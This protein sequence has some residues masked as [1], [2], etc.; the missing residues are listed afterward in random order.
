MPTHRLTYYTDHRKYGNSLSLSLQRFCLKIVSS[1]RCVRMLHNEQRL[2][3][4]LILDKLLIILEIFS[5]VNF[6]CCSGTEFKVRDIG[7]I[8]ERK[9]SNVLNMQKKKIEIHP[10]KT[11]VIDLWLLAS[12]TLSVLL[13]L[14]SSTSSLLRNEVVLLLFVA[15][16]WKCWIKNFSIRFR[17]VNNNNSTSTRS[18]K[19]FV[20]I[21]R[22]FSLFFSL[23]FSDI[24]WFLWSIVYEFTQ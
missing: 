23:S 10:W 11:K 4:C 16:T 12:I 24:C 14:S 6:V 13:P 3:R 8:S 9:C 7:R 21:F 5:R 18:W 2:Y 1:C 19:S 20:I 17:I 22:P 15:F